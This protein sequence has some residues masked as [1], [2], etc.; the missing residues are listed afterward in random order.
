MSFRCRNWPLLLLASMAPPALAQTPGEPAR[1]VK[2]V[3]VA[4]ADSVPLADVL[5]L[6]LDGPRRHTVTAPSGRFALEL[7]GGDV[8]LLATRLGFAPETLS[9]GR[10]AA[11]ITFR[12]AESAFALDPIV[13]SAEPTFSA[14]SSRTIRDLDIRLRPRETAQELLRLAPGLVIAQHAG[15]GKAEQIFL[16]GFDADHGTDVAISV[17][18]TPANM[19]SHGHGQGYAD[20]HFLMPE[21]VEIGEVRKGPYD[22]RDGNLATAGAVNFRT[23]DRIDHGMVEVRG[24]SFNTVHGF[25]MAPFGG[26]AGQAGGYVAASGHYTDGP[27]ISPQDYQRFNGFAKFTAPVG[28]DVELVASGSGFDSEWRA[29]GQVPERAVRAGRISR[30]GSIDDT[31]GGNTSRYD[32][33]LGLRSSGGGERGWEVRAYAVKYDFELFSNFTFFLDDPVNGDGIRQADD[34]TIFGLNAEYAAPSRIGGLG[35][36]TTA[37]VGGRADAGDVQLGHQ[38]RRVPLEPRV[39]AR[40][41]QRHGFAWL[42]QDL[43]LSPAVRLQ[44]GVRGDLFHFDVSDRLASAHASS[45]KALVSPK[46]N[47]A[48]SASDA[49][50]LFASAGAGF[51]SNDARAAVVAAAEDRV[52]PRAIGAE[53][54]GRYVWSGG[55]FAASLWGLDL[56]SELVYVGDEGTT[57]ASGRTRRIGVDLEGRV[58]LTRWLW[59][60]ADVN[61]SRGRLRDELEGADRIPLAPSFTLAGGLTARDLG[62]VEGGFRVRHIGDRSA[63]EDNSVVARGYTVSEV[64]ARWR[65]AG[66]ELLA[67]VDNLFNVEWN[68]AQ[69][70]TTSRLQDEPA[71]V[72]ELHFTPGAERSLQVGV[73]YEF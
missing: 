21:V 37:G 66:L 27:V 11:A 40:V 14:A 68:E 38:V 52:L 7:P 3:V 4:A 35:G 6:A 9:V 24:G 25:G 56:Q 48:V 53:L 2:G 63:V 73:E 69:F 58:R 57:E 54:G 61:L 23:R 39:D 8:R 5:V 60:D 17:D 64:F 42:K 13:V 44:L 72:T 67:A 1:L 51:H 62:P 20:L 15:G 22:A 10:H 49:V 45:T 33:N 55:S 26:P 43:D 12:L 65:V 16:R 31:E 34:R 59:A 41:K 18:G 47:L 50:T 29:S 19:V 28:R 32:L 36:R 70:A 30:F 71:E 46:L